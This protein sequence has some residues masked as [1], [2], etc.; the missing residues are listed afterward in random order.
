[1]NLYQ[2][3]GAPLMIVGIA[4]CILSLLIFS[5][6]NLRKNPCSIYFIAYNTANL[7]QICT[8]FL[9]AIL[10]Y[11]Y[12]IDISIASIYFCPFICYIGY[13]FDILSPFYLILASIDR[14]L[15]TSRNAR[16]RQRSNNHLAYKSVICGTICWMLFHIHIFFFFRIIEIIPNYYICYSG[17]IT[18]LTFANYYGLTKTIIIPILMLICEVY[19]IK[20]IQSAHRT[21][22]IPLSTIGSNVLN[23]NARF[24]DHQLI[25]ILFINVTVY[26]IFNLFPVIVAIYNQIN[27]YQM[28]VFLTS[29]SHFI[30]YIPISIGCYTNLIISKTFRN[31]TKTLLL[32]K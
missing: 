19:T 30:Y 25:K 26:I 1:M 4:G 7:C 6:K 11:G 2:Y 5:T 9:Q 24:K 23:N 3:G 28:N 15:V 8:T 20:N 12:N 31:K 16:T 29:L 21:R 14:M 32:C 13:V 27:Y 22:V 10:A 17:S 18:Y